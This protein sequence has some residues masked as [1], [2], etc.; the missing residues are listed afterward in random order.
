MS[1]STVRIPITPLNGVLLFSVSSWFPLLIYQIHQLHRCKT[2]VLHRSQTCTNCLCPHTLHIGRSQLPI[3]PVNHS[4]CICQLM[5]EKTPNIAGDNW[6]SSEFYLA[7]H[8]RQSHAA[9]FICPSSFQLSDAVIRHQPREQNYW[10][11]AAS[12]VEIQA[13]FSSSSPTEYRPSLSV[14]ES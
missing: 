13:Q 7:F 4:A 5:Q 8:I 2:I 3:T 12:L 14:C 6:K 10:L 1:K 9:D 11:N